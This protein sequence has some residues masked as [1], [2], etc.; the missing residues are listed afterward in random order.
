MCAAH[1][2][3]NITKKATASTSVREDVLCLIF[4]LAGAFKEMCDILLRGANQHTMP[5][6]QHMTGIASLCLCY[7]LKQ[8]PLEYQYVLVS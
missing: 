4:R 7:L 1:H 2:A 6:V 8:K 5:Q 3:S